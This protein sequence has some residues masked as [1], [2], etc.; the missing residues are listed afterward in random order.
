LRFRFLCLGI[1][2]AA[3]SLALDGSAD[4]SLA[5][6]KLGDLSGTGWPDGPGS[7][8]P[9]YPGSG[10]PTLFFADPLGELGNA[11]DALTSVDDLIDVPEPSR[12][13]LMAAALVGL[14]AMG[15]RKSR[16]R[17]ESSAHRIMRGF[18]M[19]ELRQQCGTGL[20]RA[21]QRIGM[22]RA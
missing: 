22:F 21:V 7:D 18:C 20:R 14:G 16:L 17:V 8:R 12:L 15:R 10:G 4:A 2:A 1:L 6:S 5:H 3:A 9:G 19:R 13:A 11:P